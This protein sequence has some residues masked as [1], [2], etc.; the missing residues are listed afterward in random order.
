MEVLSWPQMPP[1]CARC[2]VMA[3]FSGEVESGCG[4]TSRGT[5]AKGTHLPELVRLGQRA[6]LVVLAEEV[7]GHL[8]EK[9][10]SS[11]DNSTKR[12][13]EANQRCCREGRRRR[14]D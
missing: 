10:A 4:G 7:A 12:R 6:K 1:L 14:G 11:W 9:T 5:E 3:P 2:V 8:L 13:Q